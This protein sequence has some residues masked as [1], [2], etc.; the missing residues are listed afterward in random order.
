MNEGRRRR[1]EGK[2]MKQG[3]GK[4]AREGGKEGRMEL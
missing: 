2:E 1:D 4:E 3:K